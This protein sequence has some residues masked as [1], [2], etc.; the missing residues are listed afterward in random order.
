MNEEHIKKIL[1]GQNKIKNS[2]TYTDFSP[3]ELDLLQ[4]EFSTWKY[5][6]VAEC[7]IWLKVCPHTVRKLIQNN[8]ICATQITGEKKC[9]YKIDVEK[10]KKLLGL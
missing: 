10:T 9:P 1:N 5:L 2:H 7:G 8:K 3:K 6:T 4:K